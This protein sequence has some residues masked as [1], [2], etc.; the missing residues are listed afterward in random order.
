[1]P[2]R[3]NLILI[4]DDEPS[5]LRAVSTALAGAGFRVLI[6]DNAEDGLALY[7]KHQDEICLVVADVVMPGKSG[8]EMAREILQVDPR[9][10]VLMISGYSDSAVEFPF[11]RKPFLLTDLVRKIQEMLVNGAGA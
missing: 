7:R 4:V 5:I 9:I 3:S 1:M 6:A 2:P 10:K 8:L 11:I